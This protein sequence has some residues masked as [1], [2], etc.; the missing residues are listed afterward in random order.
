MEYE[1]TIRFQW[2]L[3]R[4]DNCYALSNIKEKYFSRW[5]PRWR[6]RW[7]P[8]IQ[9]NRISALLL[10]MN[11]NK[12]FSNMNCETERSNIQKSITPVA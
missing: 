8:K 2:F 4:G 5:R 7:P 10:D 9:F 6:P 1:I 3:I 12:V 11:A